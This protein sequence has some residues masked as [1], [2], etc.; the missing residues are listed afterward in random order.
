MRL[1]LLNTLQYFGQ[2]RK[3]ECLPSWRRAEA[4][5]EGRHVY[6]PDISGLEP[7]RQ[8]Q[9]IY[10]N[11]QRCKRVHIFNSPVGVIR[12]GIG[13]TGPIAMHSDKRDHNTVMG[14]MTFKDKVFDCWHRSRG[15][16]QSHP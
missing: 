7:P 1:P 12:I 6:E 3:R 10:L 8:A 9:S 16:M 4:N 14:W 2:P 11:H 5:E 15:P 13:S